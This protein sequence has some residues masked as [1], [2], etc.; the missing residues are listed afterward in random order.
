M[1]ALS[2]D[3]PPP[4]LSATAAALGALAPVFDI[5]WLACVT[6][7]NSVLMDALP[8]DDGRVQVLA[9][10]RQ[11][12][13]RGRRG[14]RWQSWPGASLT[15]SVLWRFGPQTPAPVGLS[16]VVGLALALAL[17][18]LG[19]SGLALKWPNDV[20]VG[21]RKLAGVLVELSSS[22]GR[23]AAVIGIG[24]NLT[25]PADAV[26]PDQAVT[27]L[28]SELA[29]PPTREALLGSVLAELHPLLAIYSHGG[30]AVLR[31][32]WQQRN[33]FAGL[34]VRIVGESDELRGICQ[35]V[36]EDG[37]LLLRVGDEA[38]RVFSGEISLRAA[39]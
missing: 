14:R 7:T 1:N 34:P 33:A 31:P 35:G 21:G 22:G 37:A 15:F 23:T 4:D 17:E 24:V 3:F 25:L 18:K 11:T 26:I 10:T 8:A 36:D 38:R 27:D 12:A 20:L 19:V 29:H 5:R 9:A 32:A 2:D 6:S 28:A 13:G 16:L 39:P 30:F